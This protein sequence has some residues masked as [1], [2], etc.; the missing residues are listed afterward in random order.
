MAM[1]RKTLLQ[2]NGHRPQKNRRTRTAMTATA[3]TTAKCTDS[4]N[5]CN[6][7][8]DTYITVINKFPIL[9]SLHFLG[10]FTRRSDF[11]IVSCVLL[12]VQFEGDAENY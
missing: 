1:K 3:A 7:L 11:L 12:I 10:F 9:P 8:N 6:T 4:Y 5:P 2:V